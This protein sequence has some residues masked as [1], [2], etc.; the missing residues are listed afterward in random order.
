M[1]KDALLERIEL[2]AERYEAGVPQYELNGIY[3]VPVET[4]WS[5]T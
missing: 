2:E 1:A 3:C 5:S 4:R